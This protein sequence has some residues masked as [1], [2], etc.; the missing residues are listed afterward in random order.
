MPE[1]LRRVM[2]G[3]PRRNLLAQ[4]ILSR[5]APEH[6]RC[7][8]DGHQWVF[9]HFGRPERRE[10]LHFSTC[11]AQP[12]RPLV[13]S[14]A[15][16]SDGGPRRFTEVVLNEQ[17]LPVAW[18]SHV[19]IPRRAQLAGCCLSL[20]RLLGDHAVNVV[21]QNSGL[22]ARNQSHGEVTAIDQSRD[23]TRGDVSTPRDLGPQNPRRVRLSY[24]RISGKGKWLI[25][26]PAEYN[27]LGGFR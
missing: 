22:T 19:G 10:S 16:G 21:G 12:V 8:L 27:C 4:N 14:S 6:E 18:R 15:R 2:I 1:G 23:H 3:K 9:G 7:K 5:H 13:P 20:L 11:T 17:A 25:Q 24:S 26:S